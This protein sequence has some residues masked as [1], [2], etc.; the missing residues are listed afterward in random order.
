M[1][2]YQLFTYKRYAEQV[3][4]TPCVLLGRFL[5]L[6]SSR[7]DFDIYFFIPIY[8][9]G[10][11]EYVNAKILD[12]LPDQK[13]LLIFT[14]KSTDETTIKFFQHP[15]VQI[16]DCSKWTDNK[17]IYWANF[18]MRG[19][20]ATKIK[21][22]K[23]ATQVFIGQ[24]NF[25][26]KLTPHLPKSVAVLE[27]IHLF[28]ERFCNVWMPF[29]S[30]L[31]KRICVA[32]AE[33][34]K[35]NEYADNVGIP[36]QYKKLFSEL[37]LFVEIP[38]D[39]KPTYQDNKRLKVYYAGRGT[40]QK[41][42]WLHFEIAKK[43]KE[44]SLPIDFYY[45]GNFQDELPIDIEEYASFT[46]SLAM[47]RQMYE[48]IKDKNILLLTSYS[49]GFPIALLEAMHFGIIPIVTPVGGMPT[50]I[51][52][53]ENGVLLNNLNE[54]MVVQSAIEALQILATEKVLRNKLSE[55]VRATFI[56]QFSRMRFDLFIR[57]FFSLPN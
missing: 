2:K 4:M 30:F 15:N 35:I 56:E 3:L 6:F 48:F 17:W 55:N 43:V 9:L 49:E 29:V 7:N 38:E 13:I 14:K 57:Q 37:R 8:G 25:A 50:A 16:T 53:M 36:A 54:E 32:Q 47:G 1:T 33:I 19:Y 44:L 5:A 51:K 22:N 34:D 24:C 10:G 45:V 28:D 39:I 27:L 52:H 46:P 41:R 20:F 42:L 31:H 18:M 12:A 40:A 21:G 11:A 23:C 26:Y